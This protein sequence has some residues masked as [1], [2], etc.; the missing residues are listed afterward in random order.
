MAGNPSRAWQCLVCGYIHEGDAPPDV[1]PIC[2]VG[3]DEFEV[4]GEEPAEPAAAAEGSDATIELAES[5]P[6]AS[7]RWRC[8]VCGYVSEG[9]APPDVCPICG[10]GPDEFQAVEEAPASAE[11]T[12]SSG[13]RVLIVGAGIAGVSA[14]DA[15]RTA[16]PTAE[17]V[18]ISREADVPYNRLNL[19]RYL[20]GE[21]DESRLPI[22]PEPWYEERRI[23][24]WRAQEVTAI[25]LSK[26]GALP[27]AERPS[28]ELSGG[29]RE[30]FDKLV[31]ASGAHGF[32][33]PIP[34]AHRQG[35][36]C[37]RNLDDARHILEAA[38][39]GDRCVCIG[40]GL[41]GLETAGALAKRGAEVT[42]VE[43]LPWLM[44]RQLTQIAGTKLARHVE[45]MGISLFT[46]ARV[47]GF[48]GDER[49]RAVEIET[50]TETGEP[51]HAQ[52]QLL[53]AD[54]VVVTAGIRANNYVARRAGLDVNR[55]VVVDDHLQTSHPDVLAAGDVA[56]HRGVVYGLWPASQ[57]Q[58][59]LAGM[60][61]VGTQ[62]MFQGMPASSSLKVLDID[63]FSL[64]QVHGAEL[65]SGDG[66]RILEH[67]ADGRYLR[68]VLRGERLVGAILMGDLSAARAVRDAV[69]QGVALGHR[70]AEGATALDL[71]ALLHDRNP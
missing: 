26:T 16:D 24:L 50:K 21:I 7:R 34:G 22:H 2:G 10:V 71:V 57:Y 60:N 13:P 58:G 38:I 55:G 6:A 47:T 25:H 29:T 5:T 56:E 51:A 59:T 68:F 41:L 61:A 67:E 17:V 9:G 4:V 63:V 64:G 31:I 36:V 62:A 27:E 52:T 66:E 70:I 19:T 65:D 69:D 42:V 43:G 28:V 46:G 37:L 54:L 40:G 35:V 32:V 49:V 15:A 30:P 18:L 3:P 1:C 33:P 8:G 39:A 12:D 53:N 45:G 14:A 44:P 23:Q 20:A 48:L 11:P